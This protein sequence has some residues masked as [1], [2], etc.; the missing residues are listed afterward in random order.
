MTGN[1]NLQK[2][3]PQLLAPRTVSGGTHLPTKFGTVKPEWV[4]DLEEEDASSPL[5]RLVIAG[6]TTI[7]IAF[8]GFFGWAYSAELGSAAVAMGTVIV[9]SKRKTVSHLRG[10]YPRSSSGAGRR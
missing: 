7:L 4:T 1:T 9:D 6:M 10:R 8:G 3:A 5:R 2:R